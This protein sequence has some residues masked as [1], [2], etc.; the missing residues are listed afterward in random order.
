MQFLGII[1]NTFDCEI[2]RELNWSKNCVISD[3][4]DGA[5]FKITNA[6]LLVPIVTL[7]TENNVKLTKQLNEV[8]KRSVN[9]NEYKAKMDSRNLDNTYRLRVFLDS[10]FQG[11]KRLF[12][13][14]FDYTDNGDKKVERNNHR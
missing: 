8:F 10:S 3:I 12:V 7:S 5:T 14:A 1:R 13:L 4:N 6:I 9:W 2:H 11:V